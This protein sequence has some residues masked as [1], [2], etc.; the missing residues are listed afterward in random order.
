MKF[1]TRTET[2]APPE[3]VFAAFADFPAMAEALRARGATVERS[4]DGGPVGAGYAWRAEG[5]F[6]G[7]VR[8][9]DG[10]VTSFD[11]PRGYGGEMRIG[12]LSGDFDIAIE[13]VNETKTRVYVAVEWRPETFKARVFLK[14]LKLAK[15]E[16]DARFAARVDAWAKRAQ[17]P[18]G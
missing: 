2:D 5:T 11:P 6:R 16:L 1:S 3:A 10:R 7:A 14:S 9:L 17:T 15:G 8:H 4:D 18:P 12:G 13:P